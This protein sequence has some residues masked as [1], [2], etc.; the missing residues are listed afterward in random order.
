MRVW[1]FIDAGYSQWLRRAIC[2]DANLDN[3]ITRTLLYN[4]IQMAAILASSDKM[5]LLH[6]SVISAKQLEKLS[7]LRQWYSPEILRELKD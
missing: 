2:I 5:A 1:A 4:A 3:L 7:W 6:H